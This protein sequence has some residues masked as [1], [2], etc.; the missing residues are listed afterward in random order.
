MSRA[1]RCTLLLNGR[2]LDRHKFD[3]TKRKLIIEFRV[4][5]QINK[6]FSHVSAAIQL[7]I[8]LPA[9]IIVTVIR[10]GNVIFLG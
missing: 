3:L 10:A 4:F 5:H 7:D 2:E 9:R 8:C 1:A 6:T